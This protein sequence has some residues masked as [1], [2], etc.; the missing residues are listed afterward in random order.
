MI[1]D[2]NPFHRLITDSAN[3]TDREWLAMLEETL[4]PVSLQTME[5]LGFADA[6]QL[7]GVIAMKWRQPK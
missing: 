5:K 4:R 6:H 3:D 1:K 2:H 7:C